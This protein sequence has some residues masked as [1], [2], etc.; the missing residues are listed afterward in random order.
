MTSS[1]QPAPTPRPA[2]DL[3]REIPLAS[4]QADTLQE[5]R[6]LQALARALLAACTLALAACGGGA[7]HDEDKVPPPGVDC[8]TRPELCA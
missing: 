4:L 7:Q 2:R 3:A 8:A 5:A 6:R 1:A